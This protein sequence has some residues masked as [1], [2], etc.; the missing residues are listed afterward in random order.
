MGPEI[1]ALTLVVTSIVAALAIL[2][3]GG[4]LIRNDRPFVPVSV[5]SGAGSQL[6]RV[7]KGLR[8]R[9]SELT[10]QN[11]AAAMTGIGQ[12]RAENRRRV[13]LANH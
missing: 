9:A 13:A 11:R 7:S 4:W 12:L 1:L 3:S 2:F 10:H 8:T 6:E 5:D